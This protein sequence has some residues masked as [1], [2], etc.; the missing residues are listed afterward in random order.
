MQQYQIVSKYYSFLECP[1]ILL[2]ASI[3]QNSIV[4]ITQRVITE[5]TLRSQDQCYKPTR[6]TS[7]NIATSKTGTSNIFQKMA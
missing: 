4:I 6:D 2:K 7:W 5:D 3:A 1:R